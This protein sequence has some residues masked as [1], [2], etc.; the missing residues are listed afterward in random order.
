MSYE[1]EETLYEKPIV[2]NSGRRISQSR[3]TSTE[4]YI[5]RLEEE[6]RILRGVSE[7]GSSSKTI[8]KSISEAFIRGN[9]DGNQ[10]RH[11]SQGKQCNFSKLL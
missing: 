6:V 3:K 4:E 10:V 8:V 2:N 1:D 11:K 9:L 5:R 7:K